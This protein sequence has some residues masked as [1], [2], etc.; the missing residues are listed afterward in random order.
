MVTLT[1]TEKQMI[2]DINGDLC[3]RLEA[4]TC[5]FEYSFDSKKD[6]AFFRDW[7]HPGVGDLTKTSAKGESLLGF[8]GVM[9]NH[10]WYHNDSPVCH[11]W[12]REQEEKYPGFI[13]KVWKHMKGF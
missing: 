11:P 10:G 3:G 7:P 6:Y 12:L 9:Y 8:P 5:S 1:I 2:A 4:M 13:G